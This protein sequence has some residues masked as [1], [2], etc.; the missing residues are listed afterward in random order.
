ME[1]LYQKYRPKTFSELIGQDEIAKTLSNAIRLG[2]ISHSYLFYG[3]RGCGKTSTARILAKALNCH[4]RKDVDPCNKCISCN[5]IS[6]S[7]SVDVV[8]IDAASHTQVQ[9]I[10]DVII[11]SVRLSPARDKYRIYILDEVHMLSASAFNALL[12]TVE[13][14]PDHVVFIMA[15]TE[16]NKVPLTIVSR[17]QTFRFKPVDDEEIMKRIFEICRMEN[18]EYDDNAVRLIVR[19]SSG[20]VRDAL[21]LLE[22]IV[23]FCGGRVDESKTREILGYPSQDIIKRLAS[24]ILTRD[25]KSINSVFR[26]IKSNGYDIF[27]ILRETRDVFSKTFLRING[28]YDG[29]DVIEALDVNPFIFPKLAR[30]INRIIDEIKYSENA[31]L[32]AETFIYTIIDTIDIEKLIKDLQKV[33]INNLTAKSKEEDVSSFNLQTSKDVE[34]KED[35]LSVWKKICAFFMEENF[36]L[37]NTL[38]SSSIRFEDNNVFITPSSDIERD[39][40]LNNR[41]KLINIFSKYGLSLNIEVKKKKDNAE[42]VK[43]DI[44]NEPELHFPEMDKIKKVFSDKITRVIKNEV[45]R[46]ADK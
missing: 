43:K 41:D 31:M 46:K 36:H 13:E 37:Y 19:A 35:N 14:P 6:N 38:I 9:N 44:L 39:I 29:S 21:S 33:S 22:K 17:C 45:S 34:N 28:I 24:A 40:I 30:K 4:L 8:E 15:T 18:I 11:D 27:A 1:A 10:R 16:I 26:D 2:K 12:K 42:F 23:S 20:A 3:P 25:I 7:S 5:E 32:V